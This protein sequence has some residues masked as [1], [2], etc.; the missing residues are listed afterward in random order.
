LVD[1][2]MLYLI[3]LLSSFVFLSFSSW[4]DVMTR[5]VTDRVWLLF[6]PA[7]LMLLA[8]RFFTQTDSLLPIVLSVAGAFA[9]S[10]AWPYLGL[11]GGADSKAFLCLAIMNPLTPSLDPRMPHILDPFFPLVVF[12]NA[13]VA[14]LASILY[15]V[16]RN[17]RTRPLHTLFDGLQREGRLRKL[18]AFLTGY[19]IPVDELESKSFLFP[20]ETVRWQG[21]RF[22]RHFKFQF[23]VNTDPQKEFTQIIAAR[24]SGLLHDAVWVSPGLPFLLFMT[25]GLT[26]ALIVGDM[27]WHVV[28]AVLSFAGAPG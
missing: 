16:L 27:V 19:R 12:C 23:D 9:I 11:W 28:W 6:Y 10:I 7:G 22:T 18:A 14:S 26:L 3:G 13:Y 25:A 17:L 21:S 15:A 1:V 24:D 4:K 8:T 2:W 5:E 20:L